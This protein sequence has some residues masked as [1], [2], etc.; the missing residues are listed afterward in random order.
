MLR[1]GAV[2]SCVDQL[3]FLGFRINAGSG[4]NATIQQNLPVLEISAVILLRT[5][6]YLLQGQ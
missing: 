4:T 6:E 2:R 3:A 1:E 5:T